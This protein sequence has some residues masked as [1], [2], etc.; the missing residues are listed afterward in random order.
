MPAAPACRGARAVYWRTGPGTGAHVEGMRDRA[1][2]DAWEPALPAFALPRTPPVTV[3]ILEI[4]SGCHSVSRATALEVRRLFGE[5]TRVEVFSVDGKPGTGATREVD[6]LSYDWGAD[7]ELAR[8]RAEGEGVVFYA[9]ASPPCGPY[10]SMVASALRDRDLRWGDSVAQRCLELMAYFRPHYWTVESRGP[11]GLDSRVFM[12]KLEPIRS[13]VNYCRYG[14][15]RWKATSI[16][17]NVTWQPEPRCSCRLSKC[18]EHFREHGTHLD[19]VQKAT[20]RAADYAAL[21]EALVRA[22]TRAAYV[23]S[24]AGARAEEAG[25]LTES[26]RGE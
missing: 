22:W 20:H 26:S 25:D 19:K 16:W 4:Y 9:H 14:M 24:E 13:T 17:T 18:C 23:R 11:P 8:F 6:I 2:L 5:E 1:T 7:E 15:N 10:S 21:P 12:R 3:R